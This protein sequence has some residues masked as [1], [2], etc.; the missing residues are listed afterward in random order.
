MSGPKPARRL[1]VGAE[2]LAKQVAF[3][4]WAPRRR[5]V[6]VVLERERG[7]SSTSPLSA[8]GNGYFSGV[9][10]DAGAGTRYRYQVDGEESYPDPASRFQPEGPHGPSQVVDASCFPW[11]DQN[12]PGI[13]LPGQVMY[14]LHI[15]TFTREGT[16]AAAMREMP[17]L[18]ELGITAIEVMPVA[19]FPGKFGWGYD[20]VNLFAPTRL[21][22]EPDDFRRFVDRAHALGLGVLLDVV[23]NHLGP[24]GNY[25]AQF[26]ADYLTK[27]NTTDWGEAINFDGAN[28]GPVRE[29]YVANAGYWID[30][31][32]L[33]G[34]R[35]DATQN[36]CDSSK[37]HILAAIGRRVR[38]AA[39]GRS[40]IVV[41]EN[42]PQETRIVRP[43][44][45]GGDGLDGFWN[46]DFHHTA[47]VALTGRNEAYYTDFHG[48]PQELVST[49]KWC[50]LYQGQYYDWHKVRR[51][52][53]T[54]GLPP[55]TFVNYLQ[56][57]DQISN[58]GRGERIHQLTSPGRHRALT[59]LLLLGP[60]TPLLFQGQEFSASA[61]WYFFADH[62]PDLAKL[63]VKGRHEFLQQ[64]PSVRDPEMQPCLPIPHDPEAFAKC[65][66]DFSERKRHAT[67]YAMHCDLLRLRR[68][69]PVFRAQRPGGVDG[70]VLSEQAFVLRFFG[71]QDGDRLMLV[72]LGRDLDLMPAPEPLLAPPAENQ[73]RFLWSSEQ[74]RYGGSGVLSLNPDEPL[75]LQG[76]SA[77]VLTS[78]AGAHG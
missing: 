7:Q 55:S 63:V 23:Y 15:G 6:A 58:T 78:E 68:E 29:F 74:P 62:N 67:A 10:S 66:L 22:G 49:T 48:T 27:R 60:G 76:E 45:Q 51:G 40:T 71:Q 19:E 43:L 39:R 44:E 13:S 14:E 17:A 50:Y 25:L 73:W 30:E 26:S 69:D 70:A 31:Y 41:A 53:P 75:R 1:P 37:D 56:N 52:G 77:L 11:T 34:L 38:Q 28:A 20:G 61:P 65:K 46:D 24:D 16:W 35:L 2:V 36:I 59:A 64:F 8:E 72:N 4:V 54:F 42:E 3:R 32:H 12:W 18:V 33:D 47:R 21:Y 9:C 57:H 5:Q